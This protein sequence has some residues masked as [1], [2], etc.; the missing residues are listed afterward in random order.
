MRAK[1]LDRAW[2]D[3]GGDQGWCAEGQGFAAASGRLFET[4]HRRIEV[5]ERAPGNL[6]E[7]RSLHRR[8]DMARRPIKQAEAYLGFQ[9]ADQHTQP[10][11][12]DVERFGRAREASMMRDEDERA[13]L[14]GAEI[15]HCC[16]LYTSDASDE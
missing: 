14:A 13:K 3:V 10:G 15:H 6:H 7:L 11:W 9:F 2:E 16:L 8:R 5:V 12:R 4:R 1:L